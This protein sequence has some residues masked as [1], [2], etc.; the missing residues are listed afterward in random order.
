VRVKDTIRSQ[1]EHVDKETVS[2]ETSSRGDRILAV[3]RTRDLLGIK[4]VSINLP[5]YSEKMI[6]RELADLVAG[7]RV[8]K[9]GSKRWSRYGVVL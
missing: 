3:L 9:V 7:G 4:D 1:G 5:E 8:R 2:A 6:Q